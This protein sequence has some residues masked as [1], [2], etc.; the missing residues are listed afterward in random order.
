MS[1]DSAHALEAD[2]AVEPVPATRKTL[3][4]SLYYFTGRAPLTAT[5]DSY[6]FLVETARFAEQHGFHAVWTPERHFHQFGGLFPNP[7]ILSAALA[8]ITERVRIRAGSV[9]LPLHHPIRLVEEW[10]VV[11][12][13]SNG[14]V[15]ISVAT[16]WHARDFVIR[17]EA[18]ADRVERTRQ[19]IETVR[20]LWAGEEVGFPGVDGEV[21]GV[22][23]LP[24]PVQPQLPIWVTSGGNPDTF[25]AAGRMGTNV[26]TALMGLSV[27]ELDQM[28]QG[29]FEAREA[30]GHDRQSA[31]VTVMLHTFLAPTEARAREIVEVPLQTYLRSYLRQHEDAGIDETLPAEEDLERQVR[32]AFERY[33]RKASLLGT[34]EKGAALLDQL[35]AAGVTEVACLV[36]FG[37]GLDEVMDSLQLLAELR[38][39]YEEPSP[40]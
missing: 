23:T 37:V 31:E 6:R 8:M 25:A 36:D 26:L 29:Y 40:A 9:V 33:F 11:D 15:G 7:S 32:F 16:G 21:Q 4:F 20:R 34:P 38:A 13:L 17:P 35:V 39:C 28:L 12:N 5:G 14:R 19:G 18:Y 22:R 24:R 3:R 10:S 27:A 30:N 1:V 2:E